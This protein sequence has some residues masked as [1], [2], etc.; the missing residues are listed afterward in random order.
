MATKFFRFN[1]DNKY[2]LSLE[3]F[4]KEANK[5]IKALMTDAPFKRQ[6]ELKNEKF[7]RNETG[8]KVLSTVCTFCN[9]KHKCWDNLQYLPQ[10][11]SK[12]TNPAYYWY[13][14]INNPRM[15]ESEEN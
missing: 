7:G 14:E 8:N 6:F 4:K 10:Q 9:Y 12:A 2:L 11:Q 5:N 15:V 3:D 13:A 1:I